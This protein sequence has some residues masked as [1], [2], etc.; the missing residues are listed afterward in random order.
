MLC[1]HLCMQ[2]V[3]VTLHGPRLCGS[4][5]VVWLPCQAKVWSCPGLC[6]CSCVSDRLPACAAPLQANICNSGGNPVADPRVW[7]L[8]KFS[9]PGCVCGSVKVCGTRV[10]AIQELRCLVWIMCFAAV[11]GVLDAQE[12][13]KARMCWWTSGCVGKQSKDGAVLCRL[14]EWWI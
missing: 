5:C 8:R 7:V 1:Q 6:A 12:T 11:Q 4:L 2:A 14:D 13:L 3:P 10:T 9:K